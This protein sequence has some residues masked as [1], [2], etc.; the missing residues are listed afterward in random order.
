MA[1]MSSCATCDPMEK[2]VGQDSSSICPTS[3]PKIMSLSS[4]LAKLNGRSATAFTF[5]D[6]STNERKPL[7]PCNTGTAM[8]ENVNDVPGLL[9]KPCPA[10]TEVGD[11]LKQKDLR[12]EETHP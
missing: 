5:L 3:W 11:G 2:F 7:N 1:T 12:R 10:C 6:C 9:C 4:K 8:P